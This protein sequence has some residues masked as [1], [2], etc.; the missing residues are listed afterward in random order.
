FCV[1]LMK[2]P[3]GEIAVYQFEDDTFVLHNDLYQ[4]NMAE[5]YW[6]DGI[7]ERYAIFDL[8]FRSMPFNSGYAVFNGLKRVIDYIEKLYFSN[9]YNEYLKSNSYHVDILI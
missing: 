2:K 4:I 1:K 9:S 5:S 8:Y 3:I 7:H 6:N